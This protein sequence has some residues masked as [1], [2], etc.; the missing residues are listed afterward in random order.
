MIT[1]EDIVKRIGQKD[2]TTYPHRGN[3][4]YS[5]EWNY[6]NSA[7]TVMGDPYILLSHGKVTVGFE[8]KHLE[9]NDYVMIEID[10]TEKLDAFLVLVGWPLAENS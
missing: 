2:L 1:K 5:Y 9:S 10:S 8:I 3:R 4:S 6:Y 7:I